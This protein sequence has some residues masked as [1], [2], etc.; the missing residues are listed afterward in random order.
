MHESRDRCGWRGG[1][2]GIA[3]AAENI[4]FFGGEAEGSEEGRPALMFYDAD[5]TT[6]IRTKM[7]LTIEE[8]EDDFGGA[9]LKLK[10]RV[11]A[12]EGLCFQLQS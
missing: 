3:V 11:P 7:R 2:S 9:S 5:G 12:S 4:F 6:A 8:E 10:Q 1:V